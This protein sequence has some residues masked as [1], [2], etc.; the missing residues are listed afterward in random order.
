MWGKRSI[1][2]RRSFADAQ[3]DG[4]GLFGVIPNEG[5]RS[6]GST[7]SDLLCSGLLR[8]LVPIP[9]CIHSTSPPYKLW[10]VRPRREHHIVRRQGGS[11]NSGRDKPLRGR[12]VKLALVPSGLK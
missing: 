5:C 9:T 4:R 8:G 6:E 1:A 2:S 11:E 3:D 7:R 10:E 12:V